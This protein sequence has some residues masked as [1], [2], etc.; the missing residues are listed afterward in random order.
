MFDEKEDLLYQD[1]TVLVIIG[2]SCSALNGSRQ[3]G[4]NQDGYQPTG[5]ERKFSVSIGDEV[6]GKTSEF[7]YGEKG[8]C[9]CKRPKGQQIKADAILSE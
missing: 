9:K 8:N 3:D 4:Q 1:C 7:C 6:S 5:K 2:F